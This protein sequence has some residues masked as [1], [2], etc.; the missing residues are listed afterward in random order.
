MC[1]SLAERKPTHCNLNPSET[2]TEKYYQE[3]DKMDQKLHHLWPSLANLKGPI[4]QHDNARLHSQ[5]HLKNL[6]VLAQM[7]TPSNMQADAEHNIRQWKERLSVAWPLKK[8]R[9]YLER[10][11]VP[12]ASD[13]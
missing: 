4:L 1:V 6:K 12:V 9:G 5:T 13:R 8:F 2:I 3:I 7:N 10:S 11:E